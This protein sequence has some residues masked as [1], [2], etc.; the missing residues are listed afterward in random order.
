MTA[1]TAVGTQ[2]LRSL[3]EDSQ[4][5]LVEA[6]DLHRALDQL[7]KRLGVSITKPEEPSYD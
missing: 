5:G 4:Y 7:E 3:I 1:I 2:K 6:N